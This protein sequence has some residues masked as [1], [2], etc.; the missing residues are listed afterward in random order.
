M[1]FLAFIRQ[2]SGHAG[3]S[4]L[5]WLRKVFFCLAG[6]GGEYHIACAIMSKICTE[7]EEFPMS[8]APRF[9]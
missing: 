9:G 6:G 4:H 2:P 1:I 7:E 3:Q 8:P 5:V